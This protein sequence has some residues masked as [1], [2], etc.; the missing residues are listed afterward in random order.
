MRE[1]SRVHKLHKDLSRPGAVDLFAQLDDL[2]AVD[3]RVWNVPP[4]LN[5]FLCPSRFPSPYATMSSPND[6]SVIS[7]LS[8]NC[9]SSSLLL[10]LAPL[11]LLVPPP[12]LPPLPSH[13][14][15]L[16]A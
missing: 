9:W 8:L 3:S 6:E 13:T 15:H 1:R 5:D 10:L 4:L 14:K 16:G 12:A 2:I 7:I 11:L